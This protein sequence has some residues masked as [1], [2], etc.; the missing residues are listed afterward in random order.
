MEEINSM[1]SKLNRIPDI[2]YANHPAYGKLFGSPSLRER[3]DAIKFLWPHLKEAYRDRTPWQ[4]LREEY[5]KAKPRLTHE[6]WGPFHESKLKE[7]RAN[8]AVGF[9]LEPDVI[10]RLHHIFDPLF[11]NLQKDRLKKQKRFFPDNNRHVE[12]KE[13]LEMVRATLRKRGLTAIASAYY[14]S[15]LDVGE[16]YIQINDPTDT[17]FWKGKFGGT[18]MPFPE[19]AYM[20]IDSAHSGMKFLLYMSNVGERNGPFQYVLGSHRFVRSKAELLIRK[21]NDQSGLD[22][23]KSE[24]KRRMFWALPPFLRKKAAFGYDLLNDS[25]ESRA[26]LTAEHKFTSKDGN[27]ILFDY[28]GVHRGAMLEEGERRMVQICLTIKKISISK[29]MV[30]PATP[31]SQAL[32]PTNGQLSGPDGK[33]KL[34]GSSLRE[35]M[36]HIHSTGFVPKTVF[37]VGVNTGTPGLYDHYPEAKYV[38][39]EP[40]IENRIFMET[41]CSRLKDAH[42]ELAGAGAVP[43]EAEISVSP[44]FGASTMLHRRPDG[45]NRMIPIVTLDNLSEKYTCQ[46]P[47]LIKIDVQG[48][49]LPVL[50]GAKKILPQTEVIVTEVHVSPYKNAPQFF[51]FV[52]FMKKRGFVIYDIFALCYRPADGALGQLDVVFVKENG[53]FRTPTKYNT[54]ESFR[55]DEQ[56]KQN[57]ENKL[58]SREAI[59]KKLLK[60]DRPAK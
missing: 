11:E 51:E 3:L 31:M 43:G 25:V 1:P 13:A 15:P 38:L 37:D 54:S 27:I 59:L 7:L 47:Y 28:N 9:T 21:A 48:M 55:T 36:A 22:S 32:A 24:E 41:M 33:R 42:I 50:E 46:P 60:K 8:G 14:K 12:S 45:E 19:T 2:D 53:F 26:L 35:V 6:G 18:E 20:H 16:L 40:L 57:I 52:E 29:P 10:E 56:R 58:K 44:D 4:H 34:Y 39:V 49:E 17:S 23:V 30:I 5:N